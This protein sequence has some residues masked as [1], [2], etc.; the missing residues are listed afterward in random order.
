MPRT[1]LNKSSF[2]KLKPR[3]TWSRATE[4]V[5]SKKTSLGGTASH[6]ACIRTIHDHGF[7]EVA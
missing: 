7:V 3:H 5:M 4:K 2:L 1:Q 6:C